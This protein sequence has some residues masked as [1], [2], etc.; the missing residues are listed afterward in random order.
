MVTITLQKYKEYEIAGC[1]PFI[2]NREDVTNKKA[3]YELTENDYC[4]LG[5]SDFNDP[6]IFEKYYLVTL[7]IMD[8]CMTLICG[9]EGGGKSLVMS[10]LCSEISRLF[11]KRNVLDFTPPHPEFFGNYYSFDDEE[12]TTKIQH[13]MN[14]LEKVERLAKLNGKTLSKEAY[15]QLIIFNSNFGLDE[16][17]SYADKSNRTNL[18]KFIGRV[19]RRRRHFHTNIFMVFVDPND[20]DYRL[21]ANRAT[22]EILCAK[23]KNRP[24][25]GTKQGWCVYTIECVKGA[26]KGIKKTLH[27]KPADCTHLWDSYASVKIS[28]T[29]DINLGGRQ[30]KRQEDN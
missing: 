14:V 1:D 16:G 30:S 20:A 28:H 12:F 22:H 24:G 6:D 25:Y 11:D 26:R 29:Q 17:D 7:G 21:I 13:E 15:K 19:V 2:I 27:L 9:E 3:W 4:H 5:M 23:D 8:Y 18:A 10:W